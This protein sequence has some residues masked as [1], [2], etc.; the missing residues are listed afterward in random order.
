MACRSIPNI[1]V[2]ASFCLISSTGQA[3]LPRF[4]STRL[5]ELVSGEFDIM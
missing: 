2:F 1:F 5:V 4:S 3:T